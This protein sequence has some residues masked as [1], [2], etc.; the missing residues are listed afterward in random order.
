MNQ[1]YLRSLQH[2]PDLN[3][4]ST[5]TPY[6]DAFE[7][8]Q[9]LEKAHDIKQMIGTKPDAAKGT[10]G[11][12]LLKLLAGITAR[13]IEHRDR[14]GVGNVLRHGQLAF[15]HKTSQGRRTTDW[16]MFVGELRHAGVDEDLIQEC[17]AKAGKQGAAYDTCEFVNLA[18][19]EAEG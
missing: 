18:K 15:V 9:L 6:S 7:V 17:M 3:G 2:A 5:T 11:T 14:A 8:R 16:T 10:E 19:V 1:D 13:L 12:G 4:D